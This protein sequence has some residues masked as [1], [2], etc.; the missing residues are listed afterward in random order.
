MSLLRYLLCFVLMT[1]VTVSPGLAYADSTSP[2]QAATT[3][4][5]T[6]KSSNG[7][8][9]FPRDQSE[10]LLW[11]IEKQVPNLQKLTESQQNLI[12]A[13]KLV[14]QTSTKTIEVQKSLISEE[15]KL[16]DDLKADAIKAREERDAWYRSPIL[17]VGVGAA[18]ATALATIL[19]VLSGSHTTITVGH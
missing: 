17:W 11:V 2:D 10:K 18:G 13:Q 15:K 16:S 5:L 6:P 9:W 8:L 14:I 1:G 12:N 4:H 3:L 7:G 19:Y